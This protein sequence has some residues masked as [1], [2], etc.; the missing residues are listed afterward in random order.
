MA[1]NTPDAVT[2]D[3]LSVD[4]P[5]TTH[6]FAHT[7]SAGTTL[8]VVAVWSQA[9]EVPGSNGVSWNTSESLTLVDRLDGGSS[10][11]DDVEVSVFAIVSPTATTAN[12]VVDTGSVINNASAYAAINITGSVTTSVAAA[13]QLLSESSDLVPEN[14]TSIHASGGDA[15]NGLF[16]IGGGIGDDMIPASNDAG[17]TEILEDNT[18]G[19][20]GTP[21]DLSAYIA[22]LLDGAP[23]AITVT[24]A[25]TDEHVGGLFEIVAAAASVDTSIT[26]P[27]GP[28]R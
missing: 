22:E 25:V 6:P 11:S 12:I 4:T 27:T 21:A 1:I 24:W 10:G 7:V 19:G 14:T 13:I 3:A 16:F 8:L 17:F 5:G 9:N 15:G 2:Y 26:V 28:W 23:S 18:G 20:A